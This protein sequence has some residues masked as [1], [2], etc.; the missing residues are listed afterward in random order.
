[1]SEYA[2]E[3]KNLTKNLGAFRL[4]NVSFQLPKGFIMG[5]IGPNGAGKTTTIRLLLNMLK[6][7]GGEI[8]I[9]GRDN[10]ACEREIKEKIGIVMD[11]T[12]FV[13]EWRLTE[14]EKIL[15]KFY[16]QWNGEKFFALL[17]KFCLE[18]EKKVKELS[19]G[20][21]MKLMIAV[22][23]SHNAELLILDEPTSGLDAVARGELM[24]IL[25]N[26]I[27]DENH[28]VLFSTHITSDLEKT[29]DFITFIGD[30]K[31]LYTGTKDELL[32]K[33]V[34]VKG[35]I[36]EL[37]KQQ[38]EKLIGYREHSVGFD[39]LAERSLLKTLPASCAAEMANLDEIV[40]RFNMGGRI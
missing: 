5:F 13:D 17:N 31:I 3:V 2:V 8:K 36:G 29:A 39:A 27:E 16:G 28:S 32:E 40:L 7:D 38:R 26:F 15:S 30:G 14:I 20:M 23:L 18:K 10:V 1:M 9:F 35:G 6:R 34:L 22:A 12:F 33:Y 11:Q 4:K 19:R 24:E 21:K 25:S 37:T